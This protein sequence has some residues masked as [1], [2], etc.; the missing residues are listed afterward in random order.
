MK[1]FAQDE[2]DAAK[3]RL[4]ELELELQKMLLPKDANDERN[5]FLEIRAGTGGDES[6]LFAGDLLR[7]YTRFAERQPLAGGSGVRVAVRSGRLPRS[8]RAAGATACIPSCSNRAATACSACRPP[9]PRAASTPRL[10][11]AVMPEAD[12]VED[13][14][15]NPADLRIDTFRASGAG[16]S[17]STRPIRPC[18]SPTCHRH[19]GGVP[20]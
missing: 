4:A 7:M 5:I 10:H 17:T 6:A 18:A 9:K 14:N 8:H 12:E 19:R 3:A 1:E 20:G 11:V 15:I 2:I 16:A 13:V